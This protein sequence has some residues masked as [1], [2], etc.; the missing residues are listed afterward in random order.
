MP[1]IES[2]KIMAQKRG[3]EITSKGLETRMLSVQETKVGYSGLP[4]PDLL[5]YIQRE[6][7]FTRSTIAQILINSRKA[8]RRSSKP[9]TLSG[10]SP[11]AITVSV[12]DKQGRRYR[13]PAHEGGLM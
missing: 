8:G 9:P 5:S 1:A 7:E 10:G 4:V 6:T 2:P 12:H 13:H 3:L 11:N